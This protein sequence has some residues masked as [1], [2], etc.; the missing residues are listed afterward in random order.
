MSKQI[1]SASIT[2]PYEI[3][4]AI[5]NFSGKILGVYIEYNAVSDS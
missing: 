4:G 1:N 2:P 5:D 3:S